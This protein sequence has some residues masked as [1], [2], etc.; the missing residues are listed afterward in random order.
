MIYP[1]R[2]LIAGNLA[3]DIE[4]IIGELRRNGFEP[5]WEQ[6]DSAEDLTAALSRH[7]WDLALTDHGRPDFDALAFLAQLQARQPVAPLIIISS[8]AHDD[9]TVAALRA[10][11]QGFVAHDKLT[12]LS[13]IITRKLRD[14]TERLAR[15]QAQQ[16]LANPKRCIGRCSRMPATPSLSPTPR[17]A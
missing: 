12:W 10:G 14:A 8:D 1:L 2:V 15:R 7:D 9:L 4:R 3:D 5:A 13:P 6:I 17:R 16:S 11:T